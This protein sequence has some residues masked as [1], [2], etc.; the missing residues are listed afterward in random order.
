[1]TKFDKPVPT[2]AREEIAGVTPPAAPLR[3]PFGLLKGQIEMASDFDQTPE[4]LIAAMQGD[5]R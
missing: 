2:S 4:D 3:R 1:M 5:E